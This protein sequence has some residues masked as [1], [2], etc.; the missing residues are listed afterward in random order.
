MFFQTHLTI[1]RKESRI[2]SGH[3]WR[4]RKAR[5]RAAILSVPGQLWPNNTYNT[6]NLCNTINKLNLEI[7]YQ[8][9]FSSERAAEWLLYDLQAEMMDATRRYSY[10]VACVGL[11][12][13]PSWEHPGEM[14][15]SCSSCLQKCT[16][17]RSTHRPAPRSPAA[18]LSTQ[19]S[20]RGH[21]VQP[22]A[23]CSYQMGALIH[24]QAI[25]RDILSFPRKN[26]TNWDWFLVF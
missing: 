14:T 9:R 24:L 20:S 8:A 13:C 11:S 5:G 18:L 26:I 23:P 25:G 22:R 10:L 15:K 19:Q 2:W 3:L 4:D 16:T 21:L 17:V 12:K 1:N 7:N 6:L